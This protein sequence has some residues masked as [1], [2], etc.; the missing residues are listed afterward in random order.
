[1]IKKKNGVQIQLLI[2]ILVFCILTIE[3]KQE[4]KENQTKNEI[5]HHLKKNIK[6]QQF[7]FLYKLPDDDLLSISEWFQKESQQTTENNN[8][9]SQ[10]KMNEKEKEKE[11]EGEKEN[12]NTNKKQFLSHFSQR[13][14]DKRLNHTQNYDIL[15]NFYTNLNGSTWNNN[16]NW[17]NDSV[18]FCN[19]FGLGCIEEN[20]NKENCSGCQI[21]SF[22][23][24]DNNLKGYVPEDIV[25][26]NFL[27]TIDFSKNPEIKYYQNFGDFCFLSHLSIT[28]NKMTEL[29]LGI[30][31]NE[32]LIFIDL[33]FNSFEYFPTTICSLTNILSIY[34]DHNNIHSLPDC[35]GILE[36]T[37][38]ISLDHNAITTI[39][40]SIGNLIN[41]SVFSLQHNQL[42]ILPD[43][44]GNL[45]SLK[46]LTLNNN[47]LNK[48]PPTIGD[49]TNLT[50]LDIYSNQLISIP[51]EIGKLINLFELDLSSNKLNF[52][53]ASL[54]NLNSI[55]AVNLFN[56]SFSEIPEFLKEYK[57]VCNL[58]M[59]YNYLTTIPTWIEELSSL[60][61]LDMSNNQLKELPSSISNI[62]SLASLIFTNNKISIFPEWI[63]DMTSLTKVDFS[64]NLITNIPINVFH[65]IN[66]KELSLS[67][68]KISELPDTF[69]N[70]TSL[71]IVRLSYNNLK[72]IPDCLFQIKALEYLELNNNQI[73][74]IP[75]KIKELKNINSLILAY[76]KIETIPIEITELEN[77]KFLRINQNQISHLEKEM[78]KN[79][80][81][82]SINLSNNLLTNTA[83]F[84]GVQSSY[85]F[86][87]N[88]NIKEIDECFSSTN[89][90]FY[91]SLRSN[92]IEKGLE[93]LM[94]NTQLEALLLDHNLIKNI[95]K[96]ISN[97]N[98]LVIITLHH[99]L[100]DELPEE[101]SSLTQ[102]TELD[103]TQNSLKTLPSKFNKLTRLTKLI[104]KQ[105]SFDKIPPVISE[106]TELQYLDFSI[107]HLLKIDL[108]FNNLKNLKELLFD[109]NSIFQQLPTSI[110]NLTNLNKLILSNNLLFQMSKSISNL[111]NLQVLDLSNNLFSDFPRG[112]Y[113]LRNLQSLNLEHNYIESQIDSSFTKLENLQY[114]KL[115]K[116]KFS[117][118]VSTEFFKL[119]NLVYLDISCNEFNGNFETSLLCNSPNLETLLMNNNKLTSFI[120]Q[121]QQLECNL[122]VLQEINF[123]HN[124]IESSINDIIQYFLLFK[125]NLQYFKFSDNQLFGNLNLKTMNKFAELKE[126]HIDNNLKITG[127]AP[128]FLDCYSMITIL[129]QYTS[130]G[131]TIPGNWG[132]LPHLNKLDISYTL[133]KSSSIPTF[134]DYDFNTWKRENKDSPMLCP[135]FIGKNRFISSNLGFQY[136]Q[137]VNCVCDSGYFRG[138]NGDKCIKCEYGCDCI[139]GTNNNCYPSPNFTN[140]EKITPCAK[141]NQNTICK[142]YIDQ[143]YGN[144]NHQL[145]ANFS[146]Q[147]GFTGRLCS[148]CVGQEGKKN[149]NGDK[150][151]YYPLNNNCLICKKS[152]MVLIPMTLLLLIFILVLFLIKRHCSLTGLLQIM[153]FFF[154]I[155]I[156][157]STSNL[158][159]P[160]NI[161]EFMQYFYLFSTLDIGIL[162]CFR[163]N[164]EFENLF[165]LVIS[166]PLFSLLFCFVLFLFGYIKYKI[167][168]RKNKK[169]FKNKDFKKHLL[170]IKDNKLIIENNNS[171]S[172]E[173][174]N[175]HSD[176][177]LPS[178][179]YSDSKSDS[180]SNFGNDFKKNKI[181]IND[182]DGDS[183]NDNNNNIINIINN[184]NDDINIIN[185]DDN[186]D[187]IEKKQIVLNFKEKLIIWF[188][189]CTYIFFFLLSINYFPVT[190][191]IFKIYGCSLS[192][193]NNIKYLSTVSYFQCSPS[194]K[195]YRIVLSFAIICT[196]VY[197]FGIPL[198][199]LILIVKNRKK[200]C[201]NICSANKINK[202][203]ILIGF[204][205][206]I[207]K[208]KYW[209]WFL[210][211]FLQKIPYK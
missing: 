111:V 187:K 154:Q 169:N 208:K 167:I 124:L 14:C 40:E 74:S 139:P 64:D 20:C 47:L 199:F 106:L 116:N 101:F 61:A 9:G 155:Q 177:D 205:T 60:S 166:F 34:L 54:Q 23:L 204:L 144:S 42:T 78:F 203:E 92:Q 76:N 157:F 194:T 162:K 123:S 184:N 151:G 160:S 114:L 17:L 95:P 133:M 132:N 86:L 3:G 149:T 2:L 24:K 4:F 175:L 87:G 96:Q 105:N 173:E 67:N 117:G 141:V 48:L 79:S 103:L 56:N 207:F 150:A 10:T 100:I 137:N 188:Y 112:I 131:G 143:A 94:N 179:F 200:N 152:S 198:T 13:D 15:T 163:H 57:S 118:L 31:N 209:W 202:G 107:N 98:K 196:V 6:E 90:L 170:N 189:K 69:P 183:S 176:L 35:I 49:L 22:D 191:W 206:E 32:K 138:K 180:N 26:L 33:N 127:V 147:A 59:N 135:G 156:I 125:N 174:S 140:P 148:K 115:S 153:I 38:I 73:K 81:I 210:I 172:N 37:K 164:L 211:I 119:K 159:L 99:N 51:E 21:G 186:N 55:T 121:S 145:N 129:L 41:L 25:E 88:N 181:M 113:S 193:E 110:S 83:A 70:N 80:K 171:N 136:L 126:F 65:N 128:E 63:G 39:T 16:K 195:K 45:K 91:L 19:W 190:S 93:Y 53:P 108:D 89:N 102:L 27:N 158:N 120:P 77:L 50:N 11:K 197:I 58:I 104:L 52:L 109:Q 165:G 168:A 134:L 192:D 29:P 72:E 161:T 66:L 71:F 30:E 44:I 146:C 68:N 182:S 75:K 84:C 5:I 36:G 178:D 142:L 201:D 8:E 62:G 1:M 130:L 28:N 43:E 97:L 85:L 122:P 46:T 82:A 18:C 185:N 12:K 7:E